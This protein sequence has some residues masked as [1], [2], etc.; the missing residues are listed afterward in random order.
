MRVRLLLIIAAMVVVAGCQGGP[1]PSAESTTTATTTSRKPVRTT[2]PPPRTT[3][4]P[5]ASTPHHTV[6]FRMQIH[7]ANHDAV[8]IPATSNPN[9]ARDPK[10]AAQIRQDPAL[11]SDRAA[12]E[13]A[14]A[15]LDCDHADP[16]QG[17][18]DPNLPLATCGG[19]E[20]MELLDR[21]LL[22]GSMI[23]N[24]TYGPGGPLPDRWDVTVTLTPAG[25]KIMVDTAPKN[26]NV[27]L[28]MLFDG[29]TVAATG[30]DANTAGTLEFTFGKEDDA[31]QVAA[32]IDNR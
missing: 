18:D 31:R 3:P 15:S 30:L 9:P 32:V 28:M 14:A 11:V 26:A 1:S 4:K 29:E 21:V 25:G 23:A 5:D 13:R 8:N 20:F 27:L 6:R 24:A 12:Q 7:D 17:K 10:S 22:D 2:T 19:T 16:L